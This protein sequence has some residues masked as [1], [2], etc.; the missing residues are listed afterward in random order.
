M[1]SQKPKAEQEVDIS[2]AASV[3]RQ[4]G[5]IAYPTEAV[6]GLGCDPEKLDAVNKI[7][8]LKQRD[9]E[10]GLILVA[11]NLEQLKKYIAPL[12]KDIEEKLLSSWKDK[13]KAKTWIVPVKN[14]ISELIKGKFDTIAIRVS[15]HPVVKSLCEAFS[16]AIVSTSANISTQEAA[17]TAKEVKTTFNDNLD[18]ILDG[19]TNKNANPSEIRDALTDKVI[20]SS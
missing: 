9:K 13:T 7:L 14:N 6:Y 12:E 11:A 16:G 17:R 19:E 8:D 4:G 1:K 18:F 15:H 3:L 20:R 5:V 2:Q 10:K